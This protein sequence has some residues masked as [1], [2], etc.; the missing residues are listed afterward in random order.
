L[1]LGRGEKWIFRLIDLRNYHD[2]RERKRTEKE[3]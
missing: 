2:R 3:E 1:A